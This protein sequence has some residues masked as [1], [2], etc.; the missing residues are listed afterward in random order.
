MR[1][2]NTADRDRNATYFS[3]GH[4]VQGFGQAVPVGL[5]AEQAVHDDD[6]RLVPGVSH[7]LMQRVGHVY[8][9]G[10]RA[11]RPWAV[12]ERRA[13]VLAEKRGERPAAQRLLGLDHFIAADV[14]LR[15]RSSSAARPA[16]VAIATPEP[17]HR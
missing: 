12:G 17:A 3:Q 4:A 8:G 9:P 10:A 16:N 7:R 14:A 5:A 1:R 13:A 15:I 2:S 11:V 6:G